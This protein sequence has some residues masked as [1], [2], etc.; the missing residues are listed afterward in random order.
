MDKQCFKCKEVKPLAEFYKHKQMA[1]GHLN[2]C[3]ECTKSDT[4][5][6]RKK[7]IDYYRA[8][9]NARGNR[10]SREY[11]AEYRQRFPNKYRAHRMVGNAIRKGHLVPK[12]CEECGTEKTHG[13]H[14]DYLVPLDVRWL[15]PV[16]HRKWHD[17]NG[18]GL[19][20]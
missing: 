2:K 18:E 15:C 17:E 10:Q 1:D 7:N 14:D 13:H 11:V 16:C 5:E 6:N 3:K 8:Y 9:D 20:P 19:N 4:R 12:D